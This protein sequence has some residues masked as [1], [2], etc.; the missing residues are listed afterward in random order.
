MAFLC[1]AYTEDEAPDE[2]GKPRVDVADADRRRV[3]LWLDLNVPYYGTS[4]SNHKNRLGSRRMLPET[5]E[6]TWAE[7]AARRCAEVSRAVPR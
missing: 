5:F 7:V 3:Y 1:E 4:S 2:N 6:A